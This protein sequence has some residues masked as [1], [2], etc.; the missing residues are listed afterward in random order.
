MPILKLGALILR[1]N[2]CVAL[3]GIV[4]RYDLRRAPCISIRKTKR[5][6][7]WELIRGSLGL[8]FGGA[9]QSGQYPARQLAEQF[10]LRGVREDGLGNLG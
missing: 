6:A 9:P 7:M 3:L 4:S 10:G 8:L 1:K 5:A 2:C